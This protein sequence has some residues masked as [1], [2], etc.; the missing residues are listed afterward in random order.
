MIRVD[1]NLLEIK[2]QDLAQ[3][4]RAL[5]GTVLLLKFVPGHNLDHLR[6]GLHPQHMHHPGPVP[7]DQTVRTRVLLYLLLQCV[8]VSIIVVYRYRKRAVGGGSSYP[9]SNRFQISDLPSCGTVHLSL[10][11]LGCHLVLFVKIIQRLRVASV[12]DDPRRALGWF[13]GT[14]GGCSVRRCPS[15]QV[16]RH[17]Q[18]LRFFVLVRPIP[19]QRRHILRGRWV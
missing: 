2:L 5:D 17:P 1:H 8:S 11:Q 18:Q 10:D 6:V 14:R 9:I 3:S 7:E 15:F 16:L 12:L 19:V 4:C 13:V